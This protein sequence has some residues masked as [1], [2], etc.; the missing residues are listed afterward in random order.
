MSTCM[1]TRARSNRGANSAPKDT[2]RARVRNTTFQSQGDPAS[3]A[4]AGDV[5]FVE[6]R[7]VT[8]VKT[9]RDELLHEIAHSKFMLETSRDQVVASCQEL[10]TARNA[11]FTHEILVEAQSD[12]E[13]L[14][15]EIPDLLPLLSY[16]FTLP[17]PHACAVSIHC[18]CYRNI[19]DSRATSC[20]LSAEWRLT[21]L[22]TF[23][24]FGTFL[25][26]YVSGLYIHTGAH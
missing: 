24:V 3:E 10:R 8:N 14:V 13:A 4:G 23:L 16:P 9:D 6:H 15:H 18:P 21:S 11:L 2:S 17:M 5:L 7:P 20:L 12:R 1:N 26:L 25:I 22:T 19:L